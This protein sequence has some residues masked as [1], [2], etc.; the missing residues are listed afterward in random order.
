[1]TDLAL[2][3]VWPDQERARSSFL[4]RVAPWCKEQWAAGRLLEIEVRLHEDAK[5]DRQR[6]YYHGVVLKTIAA[7]AR[8]NG[9]QFTLKVWKEHFR[10]EYLGYKTVTTKNPL[11]GKKVRRRVRVSSEDLGVK[12]YSRFI[13]RV[14]AFAATELGVTFPASFEQWERMQVD[15]DTGEIVGAVCP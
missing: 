3:V 5:T 14:S 12:G 6:K 13:D 15:P 2:T 8:P 9:A 10:E 11:T 7:Q 1:M 4:E